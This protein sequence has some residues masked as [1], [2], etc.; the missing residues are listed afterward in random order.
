MLLHDDPCDVH[1]GRL[2]IRTGE[3]NAGHQ[4]AALVDPVTFEIPKGSKI[5]FDGATVHL[6][7]GS[8][9]GVIQY[10]I[11]VNQRNKRWRCCTRGRRIVRERIAAVCTPV[12]IVVHAGAHGAI[13]ARTAWVI[14]AR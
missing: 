12:L 14:S 5:E 8:D 4:A 2:L 7:C 10:R 6:G 1:A 11:A 13:L 9:G 3:A